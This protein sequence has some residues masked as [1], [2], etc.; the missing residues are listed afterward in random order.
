[1]G[2]VVWRWSKRAAPTPPP[3]LTREQV[4]E[5]SQ[6]GVF[7]FGSHTW[8]RHIKIPE[9]MKSGRLGDYAFGMIW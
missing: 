4:V 6:S 8:D 7:E 2:R 5:M 3:H 1:V 9:D